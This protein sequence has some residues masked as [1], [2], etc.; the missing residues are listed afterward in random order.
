MN[1]L[2]PK[3]QFTIEEEN[4]K[5]LPF[6]DT[7]LRRNIDGTISVLVYRKPTHTDQ[8]LNFQSNHS[9][10]TKD[11]VISALFRRARDIV[12]DRK[13]LEEENEGTVNVLFFRK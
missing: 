11:A 5:K 9:S 10:Q 3:I 4:D 2:H 6:L 8:Y 13:D 1:S 7:L 12:S